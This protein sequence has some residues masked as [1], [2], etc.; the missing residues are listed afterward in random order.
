MWIAGLTKHLCILA[1]LIL[2]L[3]PYLHQFSSEKYISVKNVDKFALYIFG[4]NLAS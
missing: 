4:A 1:P 2:Y 3:V